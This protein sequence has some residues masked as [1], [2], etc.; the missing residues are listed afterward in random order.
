M[1]RRTLTF[2]FSTRLAGPGRDLSRTISCSVLLLLDWYEQKLNESSYSVTRIGDSVHYKSCGIPSSSKLNYLVSNLF[3]FLRSLPT[4]WRRTKGNLHWWWNLWFR[5]TVDEYAGSE[6]LWTGGE[7]LW[8]GDKYEDT[9][10]MDVGGAGSYDR[11]RDG[12]CKR[13]W[14]IQIH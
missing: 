1:W 11:G 2:A 7:I 3:G 6:C 13:G 10:Y 14:H 12:S 8:V 4:L 9:R 5:A